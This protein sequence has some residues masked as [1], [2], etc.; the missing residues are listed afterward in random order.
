MAEGEFLVPEGGVKSNTSNNTCIIL[1]TTVFCFVTLRI[2]RKLFRLS[3]SPLLS[4]YILDYLIR[5]DGKLHDLKILLS[6]AQGTRSI[7][8]SLL[9]VN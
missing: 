8:K 4:P 5:I 6:E 2:A 9:P 7:N 1:L 3:R